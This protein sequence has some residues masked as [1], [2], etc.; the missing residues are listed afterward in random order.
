MYVL[1]IY[2]YVDVFMMAK[3]KDGMGWRDDLLGKIYD[4]R[5]WLAPNIICGLCFSDGH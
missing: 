4:V 1:Y 5:R 2:I 3:L